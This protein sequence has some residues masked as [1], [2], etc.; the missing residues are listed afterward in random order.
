MKIAHLQGLIA[1]P[2]TP[3]HSNGSLHLELIEEY[4]HLLKSMV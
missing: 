1:A 3:M 4:Y 2:F